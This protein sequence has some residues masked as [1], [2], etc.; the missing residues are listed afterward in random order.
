MWLGGENGYRVGTSIG[1]IREMAQRKRCGAGTFEKQ[2]ECI[3]RPPSTQWDSDHGV[4]VQCYCNR[5]GLGT[6]GEVGSRKNSE[7]EVAVSLVA[8]KQSEND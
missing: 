2:A 7:E 3:R 6:S 4:A 1:E 5:C 8:C